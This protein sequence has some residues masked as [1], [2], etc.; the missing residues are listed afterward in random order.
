MNV[1]INCNISLSKKLRSLFKDGETKVT[2]VCDGIS[3]GRGS[4]RLV[5]MSEDTIIIPTDFVGK[6][7]SIMLTPV[8]TEISQNNEEISVGNIFSG[9]GNNNDEGFAGR[10]AVTNVP[11]DNK[12]ISTAIKSKQQIEREIPK[13]FEVTKNPAFKKF[14]S[15]VE[16]LLTEARRAS[17]SKNSNIDLDSITDKRQKA[18]SFE[19]KEKAE[20]MDKTAF[21]VNDKCASLAINDLGINLMLNIPYDLSNISAKRILLSRELLSAI[22]QGYVRIIT[23]NEVGGFHKKIKEIES[24]GL[25]TYGKVEEAEKA[26]EERLEGGDVNDT[27]MTMELDPND[28]DKPSEQEILASQV[29]QPVFSGTTTLSGGIRKTMHGNT[30]SINNK[31]SM[32]SNPNLKPIRKK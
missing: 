15:T 16:E 3:D 30:Q 17:E 12:K 10:L 27:G 29:G 9:Q 20:A 4:A 11:M 23:P 32:S 24:Y 22:K 1:T 8:E 5:I 7:T 31:P 6:E 25:K 18:I 13:Q 14:V 26:I 2:L 19:L 21:I 28:F